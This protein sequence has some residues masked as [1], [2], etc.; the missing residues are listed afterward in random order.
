VYR[1]KKRREARQGKAKRAEK[2]KNKTETRS[3]QT[4]HA[5]GSV[6]FF[7]FCQSK[8]ATVKNK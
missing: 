8:K 1:E 2:K 3:F 7:F 4:N 5:A 6:F